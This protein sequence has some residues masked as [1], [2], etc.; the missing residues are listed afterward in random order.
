M[1]LGMHVYVYYVYYSIR[2][3]LA[4]GGMSA[5]SAASAGLKEVYFL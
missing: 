4:I 3:S 5:E 2:R 1:H